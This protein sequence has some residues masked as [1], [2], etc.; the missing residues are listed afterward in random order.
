MTLGP[1]R[2][3]F[4]GRIAGAGSTSGVRVVV[5][6]WRQTPLG[7]FADAMVE[8]P[9]GHRVLV[10]PDE[11][12]AEVISRTYVFNEVRLEPV[13]VAVAPRWWDVRS[14]SLE[15]VLGVG[16]RSPLGRVLRM[17]PAPITGSLA[18]ARVADP[19]ARLTLGGVRTVGVAQ[20]GR[21]E[22]YSA[23]DVHRVTSL[24]GRWEG[25]DLGGLA[26]VDPPCRFGFSSTPR[27]PSVTD[28]VTTIDVLG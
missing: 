9:D 23:G 12:V 27:T 26:D 2:H 22:F 13:R 4:T 28:V 20:E 3:R 11:R 16:G 21:R 8:Q 25:D 10:A 18:F 24:D 15:V 14:D 6:W 5:G 7:P 1:G 17:L 19:V